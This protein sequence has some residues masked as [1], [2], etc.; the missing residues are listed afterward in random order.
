[1][2]PVPDPLLPQICNTEQYRVARSI[3]SFTSGSRIG[4]IDCKWSYYAWI[5]LCEDAVLY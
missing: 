2:N 3:L 1:M 5:T 4:D